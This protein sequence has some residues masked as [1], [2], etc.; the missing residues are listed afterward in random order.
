MDRV[1]ATG[2]ESSPRL[3]PARL[4]ATGL[5]VTAALALGACGDEAD[6][7]AAQSERIE[8]VHGVGVDPADGSLYIATHSGLFRSPEGSTSATRVGESTQD[9]MGFTIAGPD[10]FLGSGHP[11][12]GEDGPASLGLI[13]SSDGG[14]SWKEVS[15]GGEADFHVLHYG[16]G[17]VYGFNGLSGLIMVSDDDGATWEEIEPPQPAIDL[18][19]NPDDPTEMLISTEAGIGVTRDAGKNWTGLAK[20]IGFL[21]WPKRDAL[22]LVDGAGTV[23]LSEDSGSSWKQLGNIGGPPAA[24]AAAADGAL[25]AALGDGTVMG[26]DDGGQ[27]W[28]VRSAQ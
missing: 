6:T 23:Q 21:A 14:T 3:R 17:R 12:A 20:K 1:R 2:V 4:T 25:Y 22:Y 27:S 5:L 10:Q 13:E 26:S 28:Q 16:A 18:A 9:T 7:P 19:V 11:G 15:L 24:F 8:H